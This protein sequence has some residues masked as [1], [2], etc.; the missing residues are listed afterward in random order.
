MA[1]TAARTRASAPRDRERVAT[2]RWR[3]RLRLR[4]ATLRP[5][6]AACAAR[7]HRSAAKSI[8]RG[9]GRR[10]R[11][12]RERVRER[13]SATAAAARPGAARRER[14]PLQSRSRRIWRDRS[15]SCRPP[16]NELST[17][18]APQ[19]GVERGAEDAQPQEL[20]IHDVGLQR[21]L[22]EDERVAEPAWIEDDL[23]GDRN[24]EG[25]ARGD[26]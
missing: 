3:R 21:L 4:T 6:R 10:A 15:S 14:A 24:D 18:E 5:N 13:R 2:N 7:L 25:Y 1:A 8:D 11:S 19:H 23:D 17:A 26:A 12:W 22:R 20:R 16:Q 9:Y